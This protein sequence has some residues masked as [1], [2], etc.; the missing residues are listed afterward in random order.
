MRLL[1]GIRVE[2]RRRPGMRRIRR[3]RQRAAC[4]RLN[5]IPEPLPLP[6]PRQAAQQ[7]SPYLP[8][9]FHHPFELALLLVDIDAIS[10]DV[11]GEAA[12]R[13]DGE[14]VERDKLRR[15]VD[16]ALEIVDLL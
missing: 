10:D 2:T 16:P 14:L 3:P 13:A 11:G 12:L 6:T 7:L 8:G 1:P 5:C 9:R 4:H 15:L